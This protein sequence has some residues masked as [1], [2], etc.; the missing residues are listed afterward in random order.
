MLQEQ[1]QFNQQAK[2]EMVTLEA[3]VMT[4]TKENLR[5]KLDG[6]DL[7]SSYNYDFRN[8]CWAPGDE[9]VDRL[10]KRVRLLE[11]RN[12]DALPRLARTRS[13]HKF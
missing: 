4:L 8:E 12:F 2:R 13:H 3:K 5:L 9:E 11:L 6:S 10:T 7:P 1:Q